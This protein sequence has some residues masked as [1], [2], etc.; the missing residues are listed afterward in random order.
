[1]SKTAILVT[2]LLTAAAF[3]GLSQLSLKNTSSLRGSLSTL[4][5][6]WESFQTTCQKNYGALEKIY[7]FKQFSV[8]RQAIMDHNEKS[9]ES[10]QLGINCQAD[11]D[12]Q[13]HAY[14]I[15]L[16]S[17]L[18]SSRNNIRYIFGVES[19]PASVDWRNNSGVVAVSPIKN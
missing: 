5:Q 9:G 8:N 10:Y 12:T 4:E 7:R 6:D 16:G 3:Y 19:L 1:M 15:Q 2:L 17:G 11:V 18:Q 13:E 14:K